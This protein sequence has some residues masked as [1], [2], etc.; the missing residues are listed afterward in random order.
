MSRN[1]VENVSIKKLF[2]GLV[3]FRLAN[4]FLN[5][6]WFVPD[7]YWQSQEVAHKLAFG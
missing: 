3:V 6:T 5:Q 1:L 4:I 7:E 2:L